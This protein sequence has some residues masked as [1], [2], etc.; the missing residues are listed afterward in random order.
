M[1][2]PIQLDLFADDPQEVEAPEIRGDK[3]LEIDKKYEDIP[4]W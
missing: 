4:I 2:D 3:F 1:S